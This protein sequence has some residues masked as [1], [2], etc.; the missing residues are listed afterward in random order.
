MPAFQTIYRLG[1]RPGEGVFCDIEGL[2]VGEVALL[3][4]S[5]DLG[6]VQPWRPRPV[7]DLNHDLSRCYGLPIEIE[8]KAAGLEAV[9]NALA[10]G[11]LAHAQMTALH[12]RLPDPPDLGKSAEDVQAL[13]D[14]YPSRRR[15]E[16]G[17]ILNAINSVS[18]PNA[19]SLME[20]NK[21]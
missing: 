17:L 2:L 4:R 19:A 6:D 9:A 20:S 13:P 8:G 15:L 1:R 11:E 14:A 16:A 7:A 12:L 18:L 3:E 5:S 21:R 10:R